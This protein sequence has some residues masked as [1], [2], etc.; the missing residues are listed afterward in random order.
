[1]QLP[2]HAE[3][4]GFYH[5][6]RVGTIY[7]VADVALAQRSQVVALGLHGCCTVLENEMRDE[8]RPQQRYG[9]PGVEFVVQ[10]L[11]KRVFFQF[12][13]SQARVHFLAGLMLQCGRL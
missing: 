6:V 12:S 3:G 8:H 4:A 7:C 10:A 5:Q 2:T 11:A 1:M 9:R 13:E